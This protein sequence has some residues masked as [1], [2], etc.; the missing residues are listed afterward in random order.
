[1]KSCLITA[2]DL[3]CPLDNGK[4]VL[5]GDASHP[6]QPKMGQGA[7]QAVEDAAVLGVILKDIESDSAV[8]S[9]LAL[10]E[11]LRR[12]R[13]SAIQLMSRTNP[14]LEGWPNVGDKDKAAKFFPNGDLPC[15][16]KRQ[17]DLVK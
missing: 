17:R 6:M 14:S 9:R 3:A 13:A 1:M 12:P 11:E 15:E 16:W 10:W 7:A 2:T 5:V 4:L 8:A